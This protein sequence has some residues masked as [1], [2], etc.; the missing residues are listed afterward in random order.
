MGHW[1]R[2]CKNPKKKERALQAAH[3]EDEEPVL[4]M[5]HVCALN[6]T[7]EQVLALE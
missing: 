4:L 2:D 5:A 7:V 3:A 6:D 1:A